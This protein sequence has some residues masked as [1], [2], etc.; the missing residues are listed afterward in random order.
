MVLRLSKN[1]FDKNFENPIEG[2]M[3]PNIVLIEA[4][5]SGQPLI[6]TLKRLGV[7]VI[8]YNPG[9]QKNRTHIEI[10][11]LHPWFAKACFV[12]VLWHQ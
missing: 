12:A 7:E 9:G 6:Q 3:R 5:S 11:Q 1:I 2:S 10:S 8:P 4:K